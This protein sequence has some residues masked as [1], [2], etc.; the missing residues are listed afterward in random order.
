M[1][2]RRL[3]RIAGLVMLLPLTG[4][5]V[6]GFFFFVKPGYGA[7]YEILQP[8]TYPLEGSLSFQADPAWMEVRY[9]RTVLGGHL[10]VRTSKGWSHLDPETLQPR[11]LPEREAIRSLLEDAFTANPA[12]YGRVVSVEGETITTDTG[13]SIKLNWERLS[14]DQRGPDTD[15]I[16]FLYRVHYLQWTG[17]TSIDRV[18]GLLGLALVLVLS[19]L[20]ARLFFKS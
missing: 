19:A 9:L 15:R 11:G 17:V 7:A 5:A 8:R 13:I 18:L 20:G 6:T 10:I 16:D 4:W 14:L 3:H 12:R 1:L 2:T